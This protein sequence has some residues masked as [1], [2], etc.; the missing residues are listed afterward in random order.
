MA[1]ARYILRYRGEGAP[2]EADVARVHGLSDT[3]VVDSTPKM[4][5]VESDPQHLQPLVDGLP[6]WVMAPDQ[7]YAVPD[8]RKQVEGPPD[9]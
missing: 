6:D 4:L 3:V 8:T 9:P 2:P 1:K 5:L 7:S